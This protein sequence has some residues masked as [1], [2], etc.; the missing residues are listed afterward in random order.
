MHSYARI[1]HSRTRTL[2]TPTMAGVSTQWQACLRSRHAPLHCPAPIGNQSFYTR[3]S[4]RWPGV[5]LVYP[6]AM[7]LIRVHS[8]ALICAAVLPSAVGF[9]NIPGG[10]VPSLRAFGRGA[11][12]AVHALPRLTRARTRR[13]KPV[14]RRSWQGRRAKCPA[15]CG[16]K[17]VVCVCFADVHAR[18]LPRDARGIVILHVSA[19]AP[20]SGGPGGRR[21]ALFVI[22]RAR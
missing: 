10:T 19:S 2:L 22:A 13:E 3:R 17:R 11:T 9:I 15:A 8:A 21:Q 5:A 14:L 1:I 7:G 4:V 20:C 16:G 6:L 18:R 12:C